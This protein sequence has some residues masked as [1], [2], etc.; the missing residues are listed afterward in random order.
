MR[1][2]IIEDTVYKVSEKEYKY[3][4]ELE[5]NLKAGDY[6]HFCNAERYLS[7]YTTKARDSYTK[8]GVIDFHFQL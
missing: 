3:L 2:I 7:Q 6:D 1:V 5:R 8:V 4:K